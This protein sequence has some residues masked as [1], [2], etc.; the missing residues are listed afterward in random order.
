MSAVNIVSKETLSHDRY[1]LQKVVFEKA[2]PDGIRYERVNEVYFRPDAICVLLVD[3]Q[4][5][6]FLLT[7]Q[8][9]L[10]TYLNGNADGYIIETCAGLI[11]EGETPEQTVIR[12]AEEETGYAAENL[13]KTGNMYMS[14]G[15]LTEFVHFFIANIDLSKKIAQGGGKEGEGEDIEL[16][17][18]PFEEARQKLLSGEF[19]DAK[20]ILLLQRY[21]LSNLL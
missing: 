21:F 3:E 15:G 18:M 2:G 17:A 6:K 16:I 12:E 10:A 13:H 11:D 20:T 4:Q 5:Q 8:F 1:L 9:R 7:K 14:V 19:I